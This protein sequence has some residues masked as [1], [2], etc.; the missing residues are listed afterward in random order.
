MRSS[1]SF[2]FPVLAMVFALGVVGMPEG[3]AGQEEEEEDGCT[4][5]AYHYPEGGGPGR[6]SVSQNRMA[7]ALRPART[8][9]GGWTAR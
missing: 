3:V 9:P 4:K 1:I 2:L 5:C 8:C 6:G 7:R